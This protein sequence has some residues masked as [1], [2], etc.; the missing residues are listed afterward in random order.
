MGLEFADCNRIWYCR[1]RAAA[2]LISSVVQVW[3]PMLDEPLFD[4]L[5]DSSMVSGLHY[6]AGSQRVLA[7]DCDG[8]VR[9]FDV[10]NFNCVQTVRLDRVMPGGVAGMAYVRRLDRAVVAAL[11][12]ASRKVH[13]LVCL[14]Y[15][16]P[17]QPELAEEGPVVCALYSRTHSSITTASARTIRVW[18]AVAGLC[19]KVFPEVTPANITAVCFDGPQRKFFVGDEAGGLG[20]YNYLNC[21]P[22]RRFDSPPAR[23]AAL[24]YCPLSRCV[25]AASWGGRVRVYRDEAGEEEVRVLRGFDGH[26]N[27]VTCLAFSAALGLV[28]SA[29]AGGCV[30]VWDLDDAKLVGSCTAHTAEV[31]L[32]SFLDEYRLLLTGDRF[33]NMVL[34]TVPP[35]RERLRPVVRFDYTVRA[36]PRHASPPAGASI[37]VEEA[38]DNPTCCAFDP[39]SRAVFVG[40]SAG[41]IAAY[42]LG[43]VVEGLVAWQGVDSSG[44]RP[45]RYIPKHRLRQARRAGPREGKT[46][47]VGDSPAT[48]DVEAALFAGAGEMVF[49]VG[50][51]LEFG[52]DPM[53]GLRISP[54]LPPSA[55]RRLQA[56]QAHADSVSV[57]HLVAGDDDGDEAGA[58]DEGRAR[59]LFLTDLAGAGSGLSTGRVSAAL[60]T[61]S[62]DQRV[63]L[64]GLD[65]EDLGQ[66]RQGDTQVA[67]RWR[68]PITRDMVDRA[69]TRDSA[70]NAR[71]L[72]P[73]AP[74]SPMASSG[75]AAEGLG[76]SSGRRSPLA[77]RRSDRH[78]E[79]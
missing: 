14:D 19:S 3:N 48:V 38:R 50:A 60:L 22:M 78:I 40:G 34:W 23:V 63:R 35:W 54:R 36:V 25:L 45:G 65:G 76:I 30:R 9:V 72:A 57:I 74:R 10:V 39:R 59:S 43:P 5:N 56:W 2:R 62:H 28:A 69:R 24:A 6:V 49:D 52:L 20:A 7:V 1:V 37:S 33:G 12:F 61:A 58:G 75:A 31:T 16:H 11:G 8:V 18:D 66:L 55:V 32:A 51:L 67:E 79:D 68:F 17:A 29:C 47:Q 53:T 42:G 71:A 41:C 13:R 4:L 46:T 15:S 70:R 26:V 21:A 44:L 27:D 77:R 64:W 73:S